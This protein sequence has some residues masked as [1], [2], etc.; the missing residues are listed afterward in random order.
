MNATYKMK[1]KDSRGLTFELCGNAYQEACL[2]LAHESITDYLH[3]LTDADT[4]HVLQV[5]AQERDKAVNKDT[6]EAETGLS[7]EVLA[8][9]LNALSER[10]LIYTT[11]EGYAPK[12]DRMIG[13]YLVLAGCMTTCESEENRRGSSSA[14]TA[15]ESFSQCSVLEDG[16]VISVTSNKECFVIINGD[17]G[18]EEDEEEDDEE[19][20]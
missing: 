13:I 2:K 6:L 11:E 3:V 9:T 5:I 1:H 12:N 10:G 20:D 14:T 19:E 16:K 18:D 15:G 4:Y 17:D 7:A 8:S